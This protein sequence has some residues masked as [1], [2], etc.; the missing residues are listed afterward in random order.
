MTEHSP[1]AS[2]CAVLL[3]FMVRAS[4]AQVLYTLESPS[5]GA[6]GRFGRSAS[7]AG[8]VDNDGYDDVVVGAYWEDGGAYRAGRAHIFSGQTG[9]LLWT[10]ESP[11]SE[12]CGYFGS[13]VSGAGDV[14]DDGHDDIVVGAPC[15]DGG[16][17]DAGRAYIFSGHTGGLLWTLE[18]P[19]PEYR[20]HFGSVSEIG[21][22]NNDSYDDVVVGAL[23]ED[24]GAEDAGRAYIFSGHTGS[25]LCTIQSPN[26]EAEAE[27]G[28]AVSRA[29][30]VNDDGYVDVIVGARDEDGGAADAGRAYIL[31]GQTGSVIHTLQ[32]ANPE[33]AGHFGGSVS[34]AGDVNNDGYVDVIVGA[35]DEDGGE[36][37]AGRAYIFSGQTGS[38]LHT[39]QSANTEV[40]GGFGLSVSGA[41]DANGDSHDDIVVGA[42]FENAT[43]GNDGRA[44]IFSGRTG[45]L[46]WT[47][48]SPNPQGNGDFGYSVS[49]AGGVNNNGYSVVVV[50]AFG[51]DGGA[52]DAGR[53]YV[54]TF[55][56]ASV[57]DI[58]VTG[59]SYRLAIQGPFPNPTVGD[60]VRVGLRT[61]E[62]GPR[63]VLLSL[64]DTRGRCIATVLNGT[65]QGGDKCTLRWSPRQKL[66]PG[67][68]FLRLEA[69]SPRSVDVRRLVVIR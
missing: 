22:A 36:L 38:V 60:G 53:A 52:E 50:G 13:S 55:P 67:V 3:A 45:R 15:E 64:Y 8:D 62:G 24:G 2:L 32:S 68:Y 31:N 28:G 14:N 5:P 63:H 46:L 20:G 33:S 58:S 34:G 10:L 6:F 65:V 18:S 59:P 17:S 19:S 48:L 11:C 30:D 51:E 27:F 69:D 7:G 57:P 1:A 42:P 9:N 29:G 40:W 25:L 49:S 66:S 43:A 35:R 47:V 39:L 16:A 4:E 21:D 56:P 12:D 23:G 44:Y 26:A 37:R 41:G 61:L 54:F